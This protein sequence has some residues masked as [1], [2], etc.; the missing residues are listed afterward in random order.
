MDII[1]ASLLA[2]EF[3][4]WVPDR[5]SRPEYYLREQ[6]ENTERDLES[7]SNQLQEARARSNKSWIKHE[8]ESMHRLYESKIRLEKEIEDLPELQRSEAVHWGTLGWRFLIGG[9]VLQ[10]VGVV[11][12]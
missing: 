4:T 3:L 9:F 1:G 8:E 7:T 6:L 10:A 12:Q 5:M 11:L 2:Y